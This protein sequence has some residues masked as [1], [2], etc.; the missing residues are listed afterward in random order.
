[1]QVK[2]PD[3]LVAQPCG[4]DALFGVDKGVARSAGKYWLRLDIRRYSEHI[5][6]FFR[7]QKDSI[8]RTLIERS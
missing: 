7:I 6:L 4:E 8:S 2:R 3:C 5:P 1:M